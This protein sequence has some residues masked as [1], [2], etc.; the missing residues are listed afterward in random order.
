MA[1]FAAMADVSLR[2]LRMATIMPSHIF[3]SSLVYA[4]LPVTLSAIGASSDFTSSNSLR[5]S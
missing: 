4:L 1:F 3:F 5:R 2:S